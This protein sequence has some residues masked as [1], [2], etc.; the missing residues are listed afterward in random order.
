MRP[1]TKSLRMKLILPAS[2]SSRRVTKNPDT[3]P[4]RLKTVKLFTTN[5]K[6]VCTVWTVGAE[7]LD[8]VLVRTMDGADALDPDHDRNRTNEEDRS[9]HEE[10]VGVPDREKNRFWRKF[11]I[12][13]THSVVPG[14]RQL[15]LI[16]CLGLTCLIQPLLH[17]FIN[18]GRR[19]Y[20]RV[21][22]D[23]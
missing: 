13:W 15:I 7:I 8:L 10:E 20:H 21:T 2:S 4:K 5:W 3:I 17:L 22:Q 23:C 16:V 6:I 19:K 11:G 18:W 12:S 14:C 1:M 9:G